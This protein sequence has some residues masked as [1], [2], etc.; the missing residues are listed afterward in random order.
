[1]KLVRLIT[2][3]FCLAS[4]TT[5]AFG[6]A[7]AV[8]NVIPRGWA[9]GQTIHV[10]LVGG[11]LAGATQLWTSFGGIAQ[12]ATDVPDNGKNA[13]EVT[14]QVT[15]PETA[16]WGIHGVRV[17]TDK[18]VSAMRFIVLDPLPVVASSQ[19]N[20]TADTAQEVT[21]PCAV[22]GYVDN[23]SRSYFKFA[24]T[25]EQRVTIEVQARRLGSPLDPI[26]R[27]I[28]PHGREIAWSDDE[29][30]LQGDSQLAATL[31][32]TGE[33]RV[34]VSDIRYQGS[35]NHQFRLRIGDF[36]LLNTPYPMVIQAGV[37]ST[38]DLTGEELEGR[39]GGQLSFTAPATDTPLPPLRWHNISPL[40]NLPDGSRVADPSFAPFGVSPAAQFL[41]TEPNDAPEQA[42]RVELGQHINGRFER[43]GDVDRFVFTA[44]AG[45]AH[46]FQAVTREAGSP[47]DL[48]LQIYKS[49]G[50]K[51]AEA[52]DVG[53]DDGAI[54][55][56]PPADGDYTLV[57]RDLHQ[58][59]GSRFAYHVNVDPVKPRFGLQATAEA[60][61]VP[62]GGVVAVQITAQR[63][64][65][66]GTIRVEARN[67]P[68]GLTS[69]PTYI[70]Q[71]RNDAI[72]T[73][74]ATKEAAAG[75]ISDIDIIGI[76]EQNGEPV[77]AVAALHET[78]KNANNALPWPPRNL[79]YSPVIAVAPE[80]PVSLQ[81]S[82]PEVV[83]GRDLSATVKL[84]AARQE[85]WD[86]DIALAV[87]PAQNGIP[88]GVTFN[89]QPIKAGTNEIELSLAA[90][91][92]VPLGEFTV[93]LTATIKKDNDT[94]TISTPGLTLRV[95][96]PLGIA[97]EPAGGKIAR[98]GELKL[99]VTI[100][101]NPA[102]AG[103]VS[104][105]ALNLPKGVAAEAVTLPADQNS[106]EL[107]LKAAG[108]ADAATID[109]LQIHA[110]IAVGDKKFAVDSPKLPLTVE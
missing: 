110:E 63:G 95:Q 100:N 69:L 2:A 11:N 1:M 16:D 67:L 56:N 37:E 47:A 3:A 77:T 60:L 98:D 99:T 45:Q 79:I 107:V 75:T 20:N 78:L 64:G 38:Y 22:E 24:G 32:E 105:S 18:G 59:G 52:E 36:A 106:I 61:N 35:G 53:L 85:G 31:P 84:I 96:D 6:Q 26:V 33:Y 39:Q 87:N 9:P 17:A 81:F 15:I 51:L 58:R 83:Y 92:Q 5:A 90:N 65:Y 13:G 88:A 4:A 68:E 21:L 97:V 76:G 34:E 29:P 8:N 42:N 14:F 28:N 19:Q 94:R 44:K 72:L 50:G 70:G 43:P 82:A 108:D 73:I 89:V 27:L 102:L 49:D 74:A 40:R 7:P 80:Q 103:P 86:A 57:V 23:L 109:N 46:R 10:K 62:A 41:E 101:R 66:N 12:L 104:I 55:F 48:L 91:N 93:A 71:G 54:D 30:G 25:A